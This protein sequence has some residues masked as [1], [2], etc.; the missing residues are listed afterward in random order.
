MR[1]ESRGILSPVRLPVPPLQ[2]N[3]KDFVSIATEGTRAAA[4]TLRAIHDNAL[5]NREFVGSLYVLY[6]RARYTRMQSAKWA[7][8]GAVFS[9]AI[10]MTGCSSPAHEPTEKYI[11]VATNTKLAYWQSAMAGLSHA[12]AE[13][14]VKAEMIGTDSYDPKGEHDEFMRAVAQKPA[15]IMV[16][17]ADAS[18]IGPDIDTAIGRG[19][20]VI[21]MDSDAPESKRL[22]FVGTDNHK[23]GMQS[24]ELTAKLLGNKGNVVIFTIPSQQNLKDRLHGYQDAVG[25]NGG[26]KIMQV[27]DMKGDPTVAFD[28]TKQMIEGKAKVDAFVCLEAIACPEV[29]EV[30]N[31]ANMTGKVKIIAMD[32]DQRTIDWIQ[33]GVISAAVAQ[34][35]YTMGYFGAKLLDDIHHHPPNPLSGNWA[36]DSRSPVPSFVDTG[37]FTVDKDNIATFK[38]ENSPKAQ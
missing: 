7:I 35:P 33:K 13:M 34:K 14:K 2:L 26:I 12:A 30:V 24:A 4:R 18:V 10:F 9:A 15:G 19:V 8:T 27:V 21:T 16:S 5:R 25:E 20:P 6:S 29:G 1:S 32:T 11:L 17:S 37:A 22:F 38:Q 23:A 36:Q 3:E 28:T 31:R